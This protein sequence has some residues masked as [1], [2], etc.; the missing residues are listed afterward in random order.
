MVLYRIMDFHKYM[1]KS[2]HKSPAWKT[3]LVNGDNFKISSL[4]N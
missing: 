2:A 4:L 3:D 1:E